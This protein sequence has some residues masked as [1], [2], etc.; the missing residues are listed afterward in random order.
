MYFFHIA[1]NI[2]LPCIFYILL[3]CKN[4]SYMSVRRKY[5]VF[6]NQILRSKIMVSYSIVWTSLPVWGKDLDIFRSFCF[7]VPGA[8]EKRNVIYDARK[9]LNVDC[10]KEIV[11]KKE[12][13]L[14]YIDF[15]ITTWWLP[16]QTHYIGLFLEAWKSSMWEKIGLFCFLDC[17]NWEAYL[18]LTQKPYQPT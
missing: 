4:L 2:F 7:D 10:N 5:K 14:F 6:L 18:L 3:A 11:K 15:L 1:S 8:I 12:T 13:C 9:I 16:L 17:E